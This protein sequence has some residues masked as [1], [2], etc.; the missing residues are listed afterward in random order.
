MKRED[1]HFADEHNGH[2]FISTC[3]FQDSWE[4]GAEEYNAFVKDLISD[5]ENTDDFVSRYLN[6][7]TAIE[8]GYY[9][10][11]AYQVML[12]AY[13]EGEAFRY[14]IAMCG[15]NIR[16]AL[17][18]AGALKVGNSSFHTFFRN[19]KGDGKVLYAVLDKDDFY[20]DQIMD[21]VGMFEGEDMCIYGYDGSNTADTE[22]SDFPLES[23]KYLVYCYHRLVVVVMI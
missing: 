7:D 20:A 19:G 14:C 4:E 21:L 18:D 8:H 6:D 13:D 9:K 5:S 11:Q 2:S 22:M 1:L 17:S 12:K 3:L 16:S 15:D 23:G 10:S